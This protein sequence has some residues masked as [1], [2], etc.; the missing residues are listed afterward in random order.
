MDVIQVFDSR[1]Y[2]N[3]TKVNTVPCMCAASLSFGQGVDG[4]ARG[5]GGLKQYRAEFEFSMLERKVERDLL[6]RIGHVTKTL[7]HLHTM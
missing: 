2:S 5:E 4:A 7:A 6:I 1:N 3:H